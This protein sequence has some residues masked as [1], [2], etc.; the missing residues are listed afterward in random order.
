MDGHKYSVPLAVILDL[1]WQLYPSQ[2]VVHVGAGN[3]CGDVHVWRG[4][5]VAQAL[6]VE[7]DGERADWLAPELST[8]PHWQFREACVGAAEG[9]SVFYECSVRSECGL[10]PPE[11]LTK[12]WPNIKTVSQRA[13]RTRTLDSLV[14]ECN[15]T[16]DDLW[17]IADCLPSHDLLA[18]ASALLDRSAVLCLRM[19]AKGETGLEGVL[20][21]WR[22][23]GWCLLHFAQGTHPELGHAILVRDPIRLRQHAQA[24]RESWETSAQ[25]AEQRIA[26]VIAARDELATT[27][28]EQAERVVDLRVCL[29]EQS[30]ALGLKQR[31]IE[32]L[33]ARCA[34]NDRELAELGVQLSQRGQEQA[35]QAQRLRESEQARVSA[36]GEAAELR[37]QLNTRIVQLEQ[38]EHERGLLQQQLQASELARTAASEESAALRGQLDALMAQ[39]AQ[40]DQAS[41]S[42]LKEKEAL[43]A[44][45]IDK[46]AALQQVELA[47]QALESKQVEMMA[48]LEAARTLVADLGQQTEAQQRALDAKVEQVL[49]LE[50]EL[51]TKS[52]VV[53]EL[54][55]ALQQQISVA[56]VRQQVVDKLSLYRDEQAAQCL[57]QIADIERLSDELAKAQQACDASQGALDSATREREHL[58]QQVVEYQRRVGKLERAYDE[59]KARSDAQ[60]RELQE[61]AQ[62]LA[63]LRASSEEGAAQ[64]RAYAER[65]QV[66]KAE[67]K[68]LHDQLSD[69][70]VQAR[71][72]EQAR[73]ALQNT[74]EQ[75]RSE[76]QALGQRLM[77]LQTYVPQVEA[78]LLAERQEREELA[79]RTMQSAEQVTALAAERDGLRECLSQLEGTA[80]SLQDRVAACDAERSAWE[81]AKADWEARAAQG[82]AERNQLL[83]RI[84]QFDA[85][86]EEL[87]R[88][89]AALALRDATIE[90]QRGQVAELGKQ[91][92]DAET[93]QRLIDAEML[94]ADAQIE[95]IKDL[96]LR[97]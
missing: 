1:L 72:W 76:Q 52:Q 37:A 11:H 92:Q 42:L 89:Q 8:H 24:Q 86:Q 6:L 91:V 13:I 68:A 62:D 87:G 70:E 74:V 15:F 26:E 35:A 49:A 22:E 90:Q 28:R 17:L 2:G 63:A 93:R 82:D 51:Q 85:L 44:S 57:S 71:D 53:A 18:G 20:P 30:E 36:E 16:G 61:R 73:Q 95:L 25:E 27:A 34:D 12:Y 43:L 80:K 41:A 56:D 81:Q 23:R 21:A 38:V 31:A 55:A 46:E 88:C 96:M 48:E 10:V 29:A 5:D 83:Q 40:A 79:R 97:D 60:A 66:W 84:G 67:G 32:E 45:S 59:Q 64:L 4:W 75:M 94:K 7:A 69:L 14:A 65:E 58:T 54:E 77:E 33:E 50:S 3:G 78:Q 47:R 9:E 19:E 39:A